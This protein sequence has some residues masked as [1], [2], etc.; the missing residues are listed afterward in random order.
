M[1][2]KNEIQNPAKGHTGSVYNIPG[3]FYLHS[4]GLSRK[5]IVYFVYFYRCGD[6]YEF[7]RVP[8]LAITHRGFW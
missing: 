4:A 2:V 1:P 7:G 6:G 5:I 3:L 8:L